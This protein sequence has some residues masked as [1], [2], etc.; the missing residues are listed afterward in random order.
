MNITHHVI[1][2][3]AATA[4][5]LISPLA[6][7]ALPFPVLAAEQQ[8]DGRERGSLVSVAEFTKLKDQI[9]ESQQTAQ[10]LVDNSG[11][12]AGRDKLNGMNDALDAGQD[13]NAAQS[14]SEEMAAGRGPEWWRK[15]RAEFAAKEAEL[16]AHF[17]RLQVFYREARRTRPDGKADGTASRLDE[18]A[19]SLND[20]R[21]TVASS[22]LRAMLAAA[23]K[24]RAGAMKDFA[25]KYRYGAMFLADSA[26]DLPVD[27]IEEILIGLVEKAVEM[28]DAAS[29]AH[30][31]ESFMRAFPDEIRRRAKQK[32]A[33]QAPKP[34]AGNRKLF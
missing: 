2:F 4:A 27:V 28:G 30:R 9:A 12:T 8:P 23:K 31:A 13:E 20:S 21:G 25:E 6:L 1:G 33:G 10:Q 29:G 15:Q 26:A 17:D 18:L 14:Y 16:L 3:R 34:T 5:L 11:V 32:A 22:R 24:E 7:C 19:R